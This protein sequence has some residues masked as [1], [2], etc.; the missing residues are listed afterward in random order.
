MGCLFFEGMVWEKVVEYLGGLTLPAGCCRLCRHARR[1]EHQLRAAVACTRGTPWR[2]PCRDTWRAGRGHIGF[3]GRPSAG[4]VAWLDR[5][6]AL[7][8]QYCNTRSQTSA[9]YHQLAQLI[10]SPAGPEHFMQNDNNIS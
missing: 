4:A 6:S 5:L 9:N 7:P 1:F 8:A 2:T 3:L 10:M